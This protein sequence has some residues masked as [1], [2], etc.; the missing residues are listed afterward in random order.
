MQ[1]RQVVVLVNLLIFIWAIYKKCWQLCVQIV[2]QLFKLNNKSII[3]VSGPKW[4][5][6][7]CLNL[8]DI[9]EFSGRQPKVSLLNDQCYELNLSTGTAVFLMSVIIMISRKPGWWCPLWSCSVF[10]KQD[11][12][13]SYVSHLLDCPVSRLMLD[14]FLSVN[15]ES[16]CKKP[17]RDINIWS[18]CD[19]GWI[20]SSYLILLE[21]LICTLD[22]LTLLCFMTCLQFSRNMWAGERGVTPR[23]RREVRL[24][25]M[26]LILWPDGGDAALCNCEVIYKLNQTTA[27][28]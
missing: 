6:Y 14:L 10:T 24:T 27:H 18:L 21:W 16:E 15:E 26:W 8:E 3:D 4:W 22:V 11:L 19:S 1:F 5:Q 25:S 28:R 7:L 17:Y 13:T 20:T 9:S 23:L 2:L 12:S